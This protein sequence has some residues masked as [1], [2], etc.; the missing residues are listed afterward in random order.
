MQD[1]GTTAQF[2]GTARW[3]PDGDRLR[4]VEEGTLRINDS[5]PMV[6]QQVYVWDDDLH[7]YFADGRPFHRV[8]PTGGETGHW[9]APDQYDG[10]YD[11]TA[12]PVFTVT[13]RVNGPRKSY[14]MVTRYTASENA[15]LRGI[16]RL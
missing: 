7:V 10:T 9:C 16:S 6:G 15:S 12:W 8:P 5:A 14:R 3:L 4:C 1:D 11:F 2:S 13:W